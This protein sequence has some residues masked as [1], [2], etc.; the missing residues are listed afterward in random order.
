MAQSPSTMLNAGGFLAGLNEDYLIQRYDYDGS[1]N[2]IYHGT[3]KPG[4]LTSAAV[5]M[6]RK[7]TYTSVAGSD[8]ISLKQWANGKATFENI[9]DNRA[10]LSYS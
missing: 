5:W 7:Y 10:A 1:G 6:I 3:A 2:L 8:V 9:W 4:S